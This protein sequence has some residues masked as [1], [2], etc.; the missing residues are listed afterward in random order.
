MNVRACVTTA[1]GTAAI[2]AVAVEGAG[3]RA[4][5]ARIFRPGAGKTADFGP[6]DICVGDIVDGDR[7]IDHVVVACKSPNSFE[8]CCHGNPL[9]V[10]MVMR[11]LNSEGAALVTVGQ[12]VMEKF[13]AESDSSIATEAK[14][15]QLK[16]AT[17]E[18][19]RII[20]HQGRAGLA[21]TARNWL[22]GLDALNGQPDED[23]LCD[24][25]AEPT[26]LSFARQGGCRRHQNA[27]G[28]LRQI[29]HQCEEILARSRTARLIISGCKA[30]IAGAPNSGKSTLL[31]CLAGRPKAIVTDVAGTTRDWVSATCRM[32]PVLIEFIDTA[33]L[34]TSPAQGNT[35]DLIA[36]RKTAQLLADCD[37]VV[38]VVD[39]SRPGP[40]VP[41]Q[42]DKPVICVLNKSD[43]PAAETRRNRPVDT[44]RLVRIS[45]KTGDGIEELA[46]G[47]QAVLDVSGFDPCAPVCFTD[48]QRRLVARIAR[49]QSTAEAKSL[50]AEL[51]TGSLSV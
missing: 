7:V 8:I 22:A 11:L 32:G 47:I 34:D 45:A 49:A 26:P 18:G 30:V 27:D 41:I 39:A 14:F 15:H 40:V 21:R 4:I 48:R 10:E 28:T 51:L 43:L 29:A 37:I 12:V 20:A 23:G 13:A 1:K 50:T 9:I 25:S 46:D 3:S 36:Q 38:Y 24:S 31:N 33:G 5:L 6:G 42:T 16:A 44:A 17:V 19:V 2:A 35:V